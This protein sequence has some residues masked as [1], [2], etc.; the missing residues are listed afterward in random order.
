MYESLATV[1]ARAGDNV[2]ERL[3]RQIQQQE[4]ETAEKVFALIPLEAERSFQC[5]TREESTVGTA[6]RHS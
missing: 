4:R 5:L 2:T 1:A 6:G 3:A